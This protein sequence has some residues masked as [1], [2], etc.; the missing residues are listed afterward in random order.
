SVA[1]I[2]GGNTQADDNYAHAS[3]ETALGSASGSEH[4]TTRDGAGRITIVSGITVTTDPATNG[5]SLDNITSFTLPDGTVIN[6]AIEVAAF[7]NAAKKGANIAVGQ[8]SSAVGVINAASGW[9]SSAVGFHNTASGQ[10][11]SAVGTKNTAS[12]RASSAFGIL[13]IA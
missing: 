9:N 5:P 11:S 2:L 12:G 3:T 13:T 10:Y 1:M 4:A 8:K 7:K 6:D